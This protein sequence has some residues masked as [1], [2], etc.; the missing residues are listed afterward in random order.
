VHEAATSVHE[1]AEEDGE[2]D[3]LEELVR[4][5]RA[6]GDEAAEE[7]V[8]DARDAV[9]TLS[10]KGMAQKKQSANDESQKAFAE[11][12]NSLAS[13]N[14]DMSIGHALSAGDL[15]KDVALD[16]VETMKDMVPTPPGG[17]FFK[18]LKTFW[19]TRKDLGALERGRD[20]VEDAV[21][22]V[23]EYGV[24]KVRRRWYSE[25][26]MMILQFVDFVMTIVTLV[27]G[28]LAAPVKAAAK[29]TKLVA[30]GIRK[31]GRTIKGAYKFAVGSKGKARYENAKTLF[32]A[33]E[34]GDN[35]ALELLVGLRPVG[36]G[37]LEGRNKPDLKTNDGMYE[38]VTKPSRYGLS[39]Q[40]VIL[41]VKAKFKS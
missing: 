4:D 8:E 16:W 21:H 11:S 22:D 35:D 3:D 2:L 40:E 23:A 29:T 15:A 17:S 36:K 41:K 12:K 25:L 27:T 24:N 28:G 10:A 9:D 31:V 34:D 5:P 37:S 19:N 32:E 33:A 39:R 14:G 7:D 6:A 30:N 18:S 26:G 20:A 13:I 1:A 38:L